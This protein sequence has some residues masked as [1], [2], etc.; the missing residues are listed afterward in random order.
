MEVELNAAEKS[1]AEGLW[2]GLQTG[3]LPQELV[4]ISVET[5]YRLQLDLLQRHLAAGRELGG[6]K[7]GNPP[8]SL[9]ESLGGNPAAPLFADAFLESGCALSR[10]IPNLLLEVE[11]GVVMGRDLEGPDATPDDARAAVGR[12]RP[13]FEIVGGAIPLPDKPE[14]FRGFLASGMGHYAVVS[15]SEL[16]VP[17][18][19][20]DRELDVELSLD[21]ERIMERSHKAGSH[22]EVVAG[23]ANHLARHGRRLEA[24]QGVITGAQIAHVPERA[25]VYA[26]QIAG[27][28][29]VSFELTD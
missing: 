18:D 17:P 7:S 26:A 15:G 13:S 9:R 20:S 1:L 22:F 23:L 12:L 21:G 4:G 5:A 16:G 29:A 24:G 8:P 28:G 19:F 2:K 11:L 3:D 6:W 14:K 10:G 25:G 27:V